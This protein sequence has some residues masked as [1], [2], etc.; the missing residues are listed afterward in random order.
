MSE[1]SSKTA[2]TS[3]WEEFARILFWLSIAAIVGFSIAYFWLSLW[4]PDKASFF[5]PFQLVAVREYLLTLI[6]NVVPIFLI[7]VG[8][9]ILLHRIQSLRSEQETNVLATNIADKTQAAV[10]IQLQKM[11]QT[12]QQTMDKFLTHNELGNT[13]YALGVAGITS[14]WTE[15]TQF[16][17]TL[18]IHL[19]ERLN[20]VEYA[21][22]HIVTMNPGGFLDANW[23]PEITKAVENRGVDV[24]W[25]YYARKSIEDCDALRTQ[26]EW[27]SRNPDTALKRL[28]NN[29][30]KLL[31][32]AQLS[33]QQIHAMDGE[34]RKRAGHWELYESKVPNFYMAFLSIPKNYAG[35]M[36]QV[37]EGTF[38][39]V[40]LYPMFA[41]KDKY[42][43][44]PALYLEASRQIQP[45]ILGCYY[46]S[47]VHLFDEGVKLGYLSP[48]WP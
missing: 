33:S 11:Q 9:Y 17:E 48:R 38:G 41:N 2:T 12:M 8:S 25:V 39:F 47:I 26:L 30:D 21:T 31:L 18:G 15:F 4:N 43:T 28:Q 34:R 24:K 36:E 37:P 13:A 19:K 45:S 27:L 10:G 35:R 14:D 46:S 6:A 5:G 29:I 44:R 40:Y 1:D 20:H 3:V 32:H 7:Y 23:L 42:E 22:W 16:R